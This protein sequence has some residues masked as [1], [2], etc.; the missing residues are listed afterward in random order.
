MESLRQD[1][2][3]ALR[4]LRKHRGFA[5]LIVL[6]LALGI[7]AN[8]AIFSVVDAVLLR[9]LPYPE[10][11]RLTILEDVHQGPDGQPEYFNVSAFNFLEWRKQGRA[12]E[13]L[14]AMN[15][16]PYTL[17][18][19]P[20]GSEPEQVPGAAV[21]AGLFSLLGVEMEHGRALLPEEDRPGGEKAVV[22]SHKL[23]ERRFGSDP[24]VLG[25]GL[26]IDGQSHTVVGVAR[27]GFHFQEDAELWVPLALD[28][29]DLPPQHPLVVAG[30]LR[31][32]VR[33]E[34]AQSQMA[35]I[36]SRLAREF[37]DT[38]AGYSVKIT[39][40]RESIV[41]EQ[42]GGLLLLLAAVG[43]LLL[44]ACANVGNL[45]LV[46][47][48]EQRNEI[49]IRA[50]FGASRGR[51]VRQTLTESVVLA[52][53]GGLVG[54]P[55]AEAILWALP[56]LATEY[57]ALL[58]DVRLD[59]RVLAFT[60]VL[61]LVTGLLPGLLPAMK[62]ST[63]NLYRRLTAG[64][65]RRASEGVRGRQLQSGLVVFE[66]A[67]ALLLLVGAGLMIKS[68]A[69]LNRVDLGFERENVLTAQISLPETG[70]EGDQVSAFWRDLIGRVKTI[71]GVTAVGATSVL[72]VEEFPVTTTFN[73]ENVANRNPAE[74]LMA[75]F[76]RVSPDYFKAMGIPVESGRVFRDSDDMA[77][78]PV[79]VV[80]KEMA[81]RFWGG[82]NPVGRRILRTAEAA[83]ERWLTVVGVVGDVQDSAVGTEDGGAT[84]YVP[85]AQGARPSMFLVAR[86]S[87]D[88]ASLV[89]SLRRE[90]FA[91]DKEQ[92]V[93]RVLTLEEHVSGSLAPRRFNTFMLTLFA[94]V[95]MLLAVM[96]I[97][98][99]LSY[100]VSQRHHEIGIRMALGAQ[101]G[102][103]VRLILKR[104][105][106]LAALGMVI[107]LAAAF[108]FTRVME[109][110][111]YGVAPTDPIV[112]AAIGV[113]LMLIALIACYLPARRAA[114]FD[115]MVTL[116][117]D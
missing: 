57:E 40:L 26:T 78:T 91:L 15:P 103:V 105:M 16:K 21:T 18:G 66:V 7:G 64:G 111:L 90:V 76:R 56:R 101:S 93:A 45:L 67:I 43:M 95:G 108:A 51:L 34:E 114:R 2:I 25:K 42:R 74:P 82:Q 94:L 49:A 33:M 100:S 39:A 8:S 68:F 6:C 48:S 70:Y 46:R 12:F 92:P 65:G 24:Q 88:P 73:L 53:T 3:Y 9:P 110:L 28:P 29:A 60:F 58:R 59:Y 36:A 22:L 69:L 80:S 79:A 14:E 38:N 31:Q 115:P 1:F 107:G 112:Y 102:D 27:P 23:W 11:D 52:L 41:K 19:G 54:I 20:Q 35:T 113:G 81:Q 96:G 71:P 84:F 106:G 61:S 97:Y 87:V 17:S 13:R 63:P 4:F 75:N 72:P 117:L 47:A 77:A 98:S 37:P 32:G 10:A 116:R 44:I 83:K 55:L 62:T 86:S 109:N 85:I 5:I 89:P 99:V 50:A 30:L 104:G